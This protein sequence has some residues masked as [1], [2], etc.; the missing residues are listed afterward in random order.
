LANAR[1]LFRRKAERRFP[2]KIDVPVPAGGLGK[3]LDAMLAWCREH[4]APHFWDC[5]GHSVRTPED[6]LQ[7][8][9]RFYFADAPVAEAFKQ[10]WLASP[11]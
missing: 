2:H 10:K 7:R 3:R 9:A 1:Q 11:A 5:H 8:F 4:A 6:K